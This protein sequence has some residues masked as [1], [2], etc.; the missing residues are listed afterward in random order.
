[1][2][3]KVTHQWAVLGRMASS[4]SWRPPNERVIARVSLE[5]PRAVRRTSRP[6][7]RSR[8]TISS[9]PSSDPIHRNGDPWTP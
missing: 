1:M 2:G 3:A 8:S 6:S 4:A 5:P 9:L 7:P